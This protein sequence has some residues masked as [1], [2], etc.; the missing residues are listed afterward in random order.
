MKT[1]LTTLLLVASTVLVFAQKK[2]NGSIY[3][4]H[5]AIEVVNQMY[6]AVNS[7]DIESLK[8]L[9]AD[10]Y[11][12]I[13]GDGMNKDQE[14]ETKEE[15][16]EN[17]DAWNTKNRYFSLKSSSN[18]YP[19]AI[20]YSDDDF[21]DVTWVLAWETITGVGGMTGVKFTHSRHTQYGVNSENKIS[22]VRTYM[23]QNPFMESWKSRSNLSDGKIYSN[24]PNI[25]T[26]RKSI[27][28]LQ[29]GNMDH[30]FEA[31]DETAKFD[32]LF[33][34]W[35]SEDLSMEEFKLIQTDFLN[36]YTVESLDNKW[37]KYYEFD[38]QKGLVQSWWRLTVV[39]KSD[40]KTITIPVMLNHRFN[41]EV[42][43]VKSFE[44]WNGDKL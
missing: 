6:D 44:A 9:I 35:G 37:I 42:K 23:N 2:K 18:A 3:I 41:D 25:N 24:H 14:P 1:K 10:N 11:K 21:K 27:H 38:S 33:S 43:I 5:P 19:D 28:A 22:F 7:N 39:R 12:G 13:L 15:F 34:D 20:E 30:F 40:N 31:F 4:N 32:G 26:V 8:N 29:Y 17:I 36:N 16:I